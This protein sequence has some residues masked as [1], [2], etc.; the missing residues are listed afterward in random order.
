MIKDRNHPPLTQPGVAPDPFQ[1]RRARLHP[2]PA[3]E[4]LSA[5]NAELQSL[6][7]NPTAAATFHRKKLLRMH[8]AA[9]LEA[10]LTSSAQLQRENSPVARMDFSQAQIAW[11]PRKRVRA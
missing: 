6:A 1:D 3:Q 10:G 7:Q 11:K 2:L 9:R 8:D 5:I 4:R